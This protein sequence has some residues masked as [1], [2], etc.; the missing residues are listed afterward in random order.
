MSNGRCKNHGGKCQ[1]PIRSQ[2]NPGS[3]KYGI[4]A[5]SLTEE[6]LSLE[7]EI[8]NVDT[9]LHMAK[10]HLKRTLDAEAKWLASQASGEDIHETNMDLVEVTRDEGD[11]IL[12]ESLVPIHTIRKVRKRPDFEGMKRAWIA[13][14]ESL[15]RTRK[16]L[17]G[18]AANLELRDKATKLKSFLDEMD[19]S[20]PEV[21]DDSESQ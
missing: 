15:E 18:D 1:G 12:G 17:L 4:Y 21:S 2:T 7:F 5:S 16:E 14:I 20:V 9:E 8:G 19:D 13:R 11:R 3:T 6:E 10:V